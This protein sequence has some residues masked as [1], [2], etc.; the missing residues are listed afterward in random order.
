MIYSWNL[1]F[2]SGTTRETE[3]IYEV[4]LDPGIITK[5]EITF[6]TGCAGLVKVHINDEIHQVFPTNPDDVFTGNGNTIAFATYHP[7]FEVPYALQ[8]CGW[9]ED[10]TYDHTVSIRMGIL[11]REVLFYGVGVAPFRM[12]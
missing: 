1:V 8:I 9:N 4:E 3:E 12:I 6:P 2:H 10:D 7:I 5:L 11:P